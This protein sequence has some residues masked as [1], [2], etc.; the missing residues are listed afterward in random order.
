MIVGIQTLLNHYIAKSHNCY[1]D[2]HHE[3]S[4]ANITDTYLAKPKT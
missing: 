3:P 2:K 1:V 4:K